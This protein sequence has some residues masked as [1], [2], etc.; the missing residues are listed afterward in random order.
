MGTLKQA[1][2]TRIVVAVLRNLSR[3]VRPEGVKPLAFRR[4]EGLRVC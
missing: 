1:G 4:V 2:V 3:W